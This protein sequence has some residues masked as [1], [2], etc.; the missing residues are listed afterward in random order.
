MNG[1]KLIN[2][3]DRTIL[4][5]FQPKVMLGMNNQFTWKNFDLS[6]TLQASLGAK[7]YNKE[8]L[9]YQGPNLG[10][11]RRPLVE[12][13]WW[14]EAEPGDGKTPAIR[15]SHLYGF[16]TPTDY[17]LENASYL[18]FR[19]LNL[20]YNLTGLA[21]KVKGLQSLRIYTSI[22]NLLII[23]DK[24]NHSYNPEGDTTW[25]IYGSTPG[26]NEGGT[27]PMN[28]VVIFGINVGF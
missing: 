11:M 5:N 1:D 8:N 14:S 13:Q 10:N 26:F 25:G 15:I 22:S 19:N 27:E 3:D 9:Y 21:Q 7:Q 4:G 20:G 12:N 17:Y 16:D 2:A 23:K 28:R 6:L 24:N 18:N